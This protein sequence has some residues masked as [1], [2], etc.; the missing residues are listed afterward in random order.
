MTVFSTNL[1]VNKNIKSKRKFSDNQ[2]HNGVR[3]FN[4][5]P[6][7]AFSA[8]EIMGDKYLETRYMRVFSQVAK[9]LK[10]LGN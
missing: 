3:L 7:F 2:F 8:G 4:A 1:V 10:N 6:T 9:Q 5:L